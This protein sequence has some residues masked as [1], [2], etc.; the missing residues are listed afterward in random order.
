MYS[1]PEHTYAEYTG[2]SKCL[3]CEHPTEDKVLCM[4]PDIQ[5][6][7]KELILTREYSG[8]TTITKI[9]VKSTQHFFY[10]GSIW[11]SVIFNIVQNSTR[12]ATLTLYASN[13]TGTPSEENH[14]L[15]ITGDSVSTMLPV[16][17]YSHALKRMIT[18]PTY[19]TLEVNRPTSINIGSFIGTEENIDVVL[20]PGVKS[21]YILKQSL[22]DGATYYRFIVPNLQKSNVTLTL[23]TPDVPDRYFSFEGTLFWSGDKSVKYP[24]PLNKDIVVTGERGITLSISVVDDSDVVIGLA[25]KA[26]VLKE[27]FGEV[28]ANVIPL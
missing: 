10:A 14:T 22:F 23:P 1:C 18:G 8:V 17:K 2:L 26:H 13:T 11:P 27:T 12:P 28:I 16:G 20:E 19:F 5:Q 9:N 24:N 6:D 15:K 3:P 4:L 21:K 25:L 7:I